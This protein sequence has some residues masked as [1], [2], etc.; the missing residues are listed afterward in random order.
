MKTVVVGDET[1]ITGFNM[2]WTFDTITSAYM[3]D[4]KGM[5]KE[6]REKVLQEMADSIMKNLALEHYF[7]Y[8]Y[9]GDKPIKYTLSKKDG[10]TT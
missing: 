3:V 6:N 9:D 1:R 4:G 7:A 10:K 2:S 8:F 5:S